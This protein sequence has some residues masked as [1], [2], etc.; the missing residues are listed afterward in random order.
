MVRI[1][2]SK[3]ARLLLLLRVGLDRRWVASSC[4]CLGTRVNDVLL[5]VN[6]LLVQLFSEL[7]IDHVKQILTVGGNGIETIQ[8]LR[9]W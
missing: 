2:H 6:S 8:N 4:V 9:A 7:S 1:A 5:L 3:S